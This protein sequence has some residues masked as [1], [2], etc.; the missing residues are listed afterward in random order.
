LEYRKQIMG[1]ARAAMSERYEHGEAEIARPE[2]IAAIA[3][4]P[5][6]PDAPW[7]KFGED[8]PKCPAIS[9]G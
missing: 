4:L 9:T 2:L 8:E 5:W 3:E 6:I 7:R 1:Q